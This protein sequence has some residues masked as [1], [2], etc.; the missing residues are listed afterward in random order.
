V[1]GRV[2]VETVSFDNR[3]IDE[4]ETNWLFLAHD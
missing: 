3:L 1:F 4:R 2:D